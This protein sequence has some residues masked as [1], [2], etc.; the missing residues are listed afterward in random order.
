MWDVTLPGALGTRAFI[1]ED[2]V[3]SFSTYTPAPGI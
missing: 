3:Y 1:G 2:D